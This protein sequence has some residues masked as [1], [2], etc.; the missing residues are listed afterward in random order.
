[1]CFI[2]LDMCIKRSHLYSIN[3]DLDTTIHFNPPR[4]AYTCG[5][6]S[7]MKNDHP[8]F[9]WG[10]SVSH[11][12]IDDIFRTGDI[13]DVPW[14]LYKRLSDEFLYVCRITMVHPGVWLILSSSFV[15][16]HAAAALIDAAKIPPGAVVRSFIE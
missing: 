4:D 9:A 8:L 2:V 16:S 1:M 3:Q 7:R 12:I 13:H 10:L 11:P 15:L 5:S 6:Q 14:N